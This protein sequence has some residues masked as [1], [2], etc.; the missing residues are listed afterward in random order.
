MKVQTITNNLVA[1]CCQNYIHACIHFHFLP[2]QDKLSLK[3]LLWNTCVSG[4]S[5]D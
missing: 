2:P 3:L 5:G 1:D 4:I